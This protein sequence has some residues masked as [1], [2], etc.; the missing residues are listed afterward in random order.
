MWAGAGVDRSLVVHASLGR[1]HRA[2]DLAPDAIRSLRAR[3]YPARR[4][5]RRPWGRTGSSSQDASVARFKHWPEGDKLKYAQGAPAKADGDGQLCAQVVD[6]VL[7]V[8]VLEVYGAD[9]NAESIA[10]KDATMD[11]LR[12]LCKVDR[13]SGR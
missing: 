7:L 8:N 12:R 3:R 9:R 5:R 4:S 6:P 10:L 1:S 11:A 13:P 2:Y